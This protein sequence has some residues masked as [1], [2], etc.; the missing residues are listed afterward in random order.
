MCGCKATVLAGCVFWIETDKRFKIA[1]FIR[2]K[3]NMR[4]FGGDPRYQAKKKKKKRERERE[5]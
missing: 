2:T 4:I 3:H 1:L 5:R